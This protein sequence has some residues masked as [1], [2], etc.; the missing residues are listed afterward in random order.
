MPVGQ[1]LSEV[2]EVPASAEIDR[3]TV[4]AQAGEG[5][6]GRVYLAHDQKLGRDVAI[7]VLLEDVE[8]DDDPE[9][10]LRARFHREAR[11]AAQL[12]HPNIIKVYDY[13]GPDAKR[14][15]LVMERLNGRPLSALCE[16]SEI[17]EIVC[18]IIGHSLCAAL[19]H[20]HTAG[21]LHRDVKPENVFIEQDGRVVLMDFGLA[22]GLRMDATRATFRMS[23]TRLLG[24]PAFASPE[25]VT[26]SAALSARSDLFSLGSTL[27]FAA[28][29][30]FP[31]RGDTI[32]SVLNSL[33]QAAP[34]PV[35]DLVDTS[36]EFAS[37]LGVL[38]QKEPDLRPPDAT[39]A[40]ERFFSLLAH[41]QVISSEKALANYLRGGTVRTGPKKVIAK[42]PTP[43]EA[44]MHTMVATA[45]ITK[46]TAKARARRRP[47]WPF[48]IGL[49]TL[50]LAGFALWRV[51]TRARVVPPAAPPPIEVAEPMPPALPPPLAPEEVKKPRE[52]PPTPRVIG[53]AT[54]RVTVKPW[55]N[56]TIDGQARGITPSFRTIELPLGEHTIQ[57]S[58]PQFGTRKK[59][60]RLSEAG[61]EA[62][63]AVDFNR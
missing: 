46:A 47:L 27:Y 39:E 10:S 45:P 61:H 63:W 2:L 15:Y 9:T 3:Y 34:V 20:A 59:T 5:G 44:P 23:K 60:V 21:V 53:K 25:Q 6:M 36:P 4:T 13:S 31:F 40:G 48:A 19:A 24:T 29:Q 26:G 58:H 56:V 38:M 11:S 22:K 8:D 37:L 54:L 30:V 55:G 51:V 14:Q 16:D 57:V 33:L 52:P 18:C 7:K 28:T 49:F 12:N 62:E 1:P 41:H 43:D 50:L 17:P 35:Q 32:M 42:T